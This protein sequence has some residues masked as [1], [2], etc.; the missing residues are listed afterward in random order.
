MRKL[1]FCILASSLL[2][3]CFFTGVES[4]PKITASDVRKAETPVTAEDTFLSRVADAPLAEWRPGKRFLVTDPRISLIFPSAGADAD[5]LEGRVITFAGASESVGVT[6]SGVTDLT[7]VSPDGRELVYRVSRPM[8]SLMKSES[9]SVP[10]TI[11]T[12]MVGMADRLMRGQRYYVLT[13]LWRDD[14][15]NTVRERKFIPVVIDSVTPGSAVFPLK[16]S[17]HD[18]EGRSGKLFFNPGAKSDNMRTFASLFAFGDP[19]RQY[20]QITDEVWELITRGRVR[21]GMTLVECRLALGAPREVTHGASYGYLREVWQY[22]S[23]IYLLF[24]DGRLKE[25]RR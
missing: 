17:F 9:L 4:T 11:Q 15:E 14:E 5:S 3:G 1:L 24:E 12:D 23:G 25:Y 21:A 6:G 18:T 20:P 10:F 19:R 8:A 7:F 13:S 22:E 2:S 16:A